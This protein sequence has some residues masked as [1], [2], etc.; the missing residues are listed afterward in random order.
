MTTPTELS[1]QLKNYQNGFLEKAPQEAIETMFKA[2]ANLEKSGIVNNSLKVSE[3][4]PDFELPDATGEKMKLSTLLENGSVVLNFYRGE[5]CPYCNLEIRAFQQ[6]LPD[7]QATNAQ[8]V[9]ISPEQPNSSLTMKE[10]HELAFPVLS[11]VGNTV[12]RSYGLVFTLDETLRPLYKSFGIDIPARNGDESFELP[13]PATYVVDAKG[14][15]RYAYANADYTLR[16]EPTDV[17]AAAQ[18]LK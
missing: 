12:A 7:F 5:W 16:A 10:K 2:T 14:I 8:V 1:T 17:L 4:A 18:A 6:M 3:E 13:V 11:D 15:V 9:A